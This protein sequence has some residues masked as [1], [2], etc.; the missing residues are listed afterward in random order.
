MLFSRWILKIVGWKTV[1]KT[2]KLSK[3]VICVAPHTSNWDFLLG[4]LF[5]SAVEGGKVSFLMKRSWFFFPVGNVLRAIGGVPIDRSKRN[6]IT[7]Q[8]IDRFDS[9]A[10]FHLAIT[11]EG[12][13]KL[14]DTWKMGFYHIAKGAGVPIRLAYLDYRKKEMGMTET[15]YPTDDEKADMEYIRGF[16]KGIVPRFPEKFHEDQ[17]TQTR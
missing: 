13:R 4:K 8:M 5:Y 14:N 9:T 10:Q 1:L 11:P 16:Y 17:L 12:T 3:S 15:F 7:A 2:E 6:L